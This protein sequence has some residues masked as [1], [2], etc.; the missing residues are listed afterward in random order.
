[1]DANLPDIHLKDVGKKE[2]GASP[3][4][5]ASQTLD[6]VLTRVTALVGGIDMGALTDALGEGAAGALKN[7]GGGAGGVVEGTAETV[8]GADEGAAEGAK[9]A[10]KSLFGGGKD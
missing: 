4:E 1:M 2:G 5:V 8:G 6:A 9:G 10:L 3:G 7:I